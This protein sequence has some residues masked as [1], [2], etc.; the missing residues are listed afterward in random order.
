MA[1]WS[2]SVEVLFYMTVPLVLPLFV[3]KRMNRTMLGVLCVALWMLAIYVL[4]GWNET[5]PRWYD[6]FQKL[7]IYSLCFVTG[8]A[9]AKFDWRRERGGSSWAS[10]CSTSFRRSRSRG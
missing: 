3:W 2:L 5:A 6:S 1:W 9:I 4:G 10:A 8:I 7:A